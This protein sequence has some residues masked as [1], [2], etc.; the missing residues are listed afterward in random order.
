MCIRDRIYGHQQTG[1]EISAAGGTEE[2]EKSGGRESA[3]GSPGETQIPAAGST[4]KTQI[5]AA[6]F[7]AV[8]PGQD[9]SLI[10]IYY[11]GIGINEAE[12][13]SALSRALSDYY[14][15]EEEHYAEWYSDLISRMY[16]YE[17]EGFTASYSHEQSAVISR[18]DDKVLSVRCHVFSYEGGVHGMYLSLIHI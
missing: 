12:Q 3:A 13:Y 4:G 17:A 2:A 6:C 11:P 5:P 16:E 1:A 7:D 14:E 18:A 15:R 8:H 10:H 9:L